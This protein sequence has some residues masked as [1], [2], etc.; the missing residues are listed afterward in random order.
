MMLADLLNHLA[1]SDDTLAEA[2]ARRLIELPEEAQPALLAALQTWLESASTDLRWWAVRALAELPIS[3]THSLLVQMLNDPD[4]PVRQCAALG[5]RTQL[6]RTSDRVSAPNTLE[7]IVPALL[8]SLDDPDPM[9]ARLAG[10]ALAAI[11]SEAVPQL[12]GALEQG[13]PETRL[14]AVRALAEIG[15]P[16]AIPAL[17][18]ALDQDSLLME[19]WANEGLERMGVGMTYFFP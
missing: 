7:R 9:T 1:S 13:R 15:D 10:D 14:L 16:R 12:V 18:E 11:G 8:R 17:F 3:Q 6:K 2:A 5:L 4:P 19:Y